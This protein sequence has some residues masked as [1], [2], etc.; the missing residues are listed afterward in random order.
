MRFLYP[1]LSGWIE[2]LPMRAGRIL[3]N[4]L[5]VFMVFNMAVS[6]LAFSR[7]VE[8]HDGAAA[9]SVMDELMDDRFPDERIE[10]IY[11]NAILR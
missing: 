7:Y 5:I 1:I 11:P 4:A 6:A 3:L 9:S 2:K 8:R 10:R